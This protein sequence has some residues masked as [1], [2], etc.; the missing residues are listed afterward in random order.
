MVSSDDDEI[1]NHANSIGMVV[2]HRRGAR[3][4]SGSSSHG[5]VIR[6]LTDS[7]RDDV[8]VSAEN[9][10]WFVYLKPT[11]PLR[12][13]QHLLEAFQELVEYPSIDA[14][15]SVS[16]DDQTK[17]NEAIYIFSYDEFA[18]TGELPTIDQLKYVMDAE[19]SLQIKTE[20]DLVKAEALLA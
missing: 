14:I 2:A 16:A 5:D 4:T 1:L 6:D 13:G 3:L 12:T 11:S 7:D 18:K 17:P 19:A 9:G 15:V 20:A 8:I 10:P